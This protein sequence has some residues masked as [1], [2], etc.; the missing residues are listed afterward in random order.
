MGLETVPVTNFKDF[1][2]DWPLNTDGATDG[3]EHLRN[4]KFSLQSVFPDCEAAGQFDTSIILAPAGTSKAQGNGTRDMYI[5]D[6]DVARD[7]TIVGRVKANSQ[8]S[9]ASV[10]FDGDG[11]T[12]GTLDGVA[13]VVRQSAGTYRVTMIET[14]WEFNDLTVVGSVDNA[15]AGLGLCQARAVSAGVIDIITVAPNA[16]TAAVDCATCEIVVFDRG[17]DV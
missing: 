10:K 14:A 6:L 7:A 16:P 9:I 12:L 3:N 15:L 13:S 2:T 4:L 1:N 11:D 5:R 17:R 8:V